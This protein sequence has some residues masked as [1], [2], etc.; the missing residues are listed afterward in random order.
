M[1]APASAAHCRTHTQG[2]HNTQ[3]GTG[4]PS[5]RGLLALMSSAGRIV[6]VAMFARKQALSAFTAAGDE[7]H[8]PQFSKRTHAC[9]R[10]SSLDRSLRALAL[11]APTAPS[12][13]LPACFSS[14]LNFVSCPSKRL[15]LQRVPMRRDS[16]KRPQNVDARTMQVLRC[17][18]CAAV[19]ASAEGLLVT[20][21]AT[22]VVQ[23][24]AACVGLEAHATHV[25]RRSALTNAAAASTAVVF[26]LRSQAK[27]A[28]SDG[29]TALSGDTSH[30]HLLPVHRTS[31]AASF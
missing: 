8:G 26:P 16:L 19:V 12:H 17:V 25:S 4:R 10:R 24:R 5:T 29:V 11:C 30:R 3:P 28:D 14:S 7:A 9:A 6:A 31:C 2:R 21:P 27:K 15:L 1:P 23:P 18:L 20:A 13:R 22:R